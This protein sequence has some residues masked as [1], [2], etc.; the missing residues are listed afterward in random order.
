VHP[1]RL[2]L[3]LAILTAGVTLGPPRAA[4]TPPLQAIRVADNGRYFV[5]ADGRHPEIR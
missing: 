4:A 1:S 2:T 5:Q 3:A